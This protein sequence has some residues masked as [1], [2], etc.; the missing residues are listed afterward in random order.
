VTL[1]NSHDFHYLST[2]GI[3]IN[4]AIELAKHIALSHFQEDI[5]ST[6]Q[7]IGK[8]IVNDIV[9][10]SM[11]NNKSVI[12]M[13]ADPTAFQTYEKERWCM[14]KA[15]TQGIS[16]PS[17]L[18]LGRHEDTAY[19]IQTFVEG[20][21]GQD[22]QQDKR[23]AWRVLGQYAK[24]IH[25]IDVKGF[26]EILADA[27]KGEFKAPIHENYD[28]TWVSFIKYNMES[29]SQDDAL[30][31][32]GVFNFQQSQQIKELFKSLLNIHF[33][34]GLNHGDLSLKNILVDQNGAVALLDWG[35]AEV[36]IV[37][38]WE[39]IQLT[40]C[41]LRQDYADNIDIDAFLAGYGI[42]RNQFEKMHR[43]LNILLLLQAIDKLRWAIDC[44]P[45]CIPEFSR[46]A[47]KVI[48]HV[49][50]NLT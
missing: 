17:V 28:G 30:I 18:S 44:S 38:H 4:T 11:K 22:S 13:N 6:E 36:H 47:E 50:I 25:S 21:N 31:G 35:S 15:T 26:G 9:I 2:G 46:Y 10:V 23:H 8:G 39:L 34:F 42:S 32:L 27:V 12:R 43:E 5:I 7:I 16:G 40:G 33:K 29:L 20:E 48:Q 37:P 19:M 3:H 1:D 41:Q 49:N 45:Q 14:D 24:R